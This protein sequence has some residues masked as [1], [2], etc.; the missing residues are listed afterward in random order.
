MEAQV[1]TS[2]SNTN[3]AREEMI[4]VMAS[5]NRIS[6]IM[7]VVMVIALTVSVLFSF[8]GVAR[9]MM[10]LNGALGEMAGGNLD[11]VIPGAGRG[12]EIGDLA[13]TVTV[14]RQNAEQKAQRRGGSQGGA[15]SDRRA[16]AQGR[17]DQAGR[18]VRGRRRRDRRDRVL[19][20]QPA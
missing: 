6:L 17:H 1:I 8:L 9:P 7:T 14:I 5:A 11:V 13:K 4:D 15:G 20:L 16:A 10:R 3:T 2:Q 19:G 12:D 18:S